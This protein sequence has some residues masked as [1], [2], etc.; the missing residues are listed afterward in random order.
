MKKV[1]VC[2]GLVGLL[3][4]GMCNNVKA[5]TSSEEKG[6]EESVCHNIGKTFV[7][8]GGKVIGCCEISI[9]MT[10][11]KDKSSNNK[12]IDFAFVR[13]SMK[14]ENSRKDIFGYSESLI[15]KSEKEI[16]GK[17][18]SYNPMLV[19]NENTYSI[20]SSNLSEELGVPEN[21]VF[22]KNALKIRNKSDTY[23]SEINMEYNYVHGLDRFRNK[24]YFYEESV[25]YLYWASETQNAS[26]SN[27]MIIIPEFEV[28]NSKPGYAATSCW[29]YSSKTVE[30]TYRIQ[31]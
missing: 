13:C 24:D 16:N 17:L 2:I 1:L 12:N 23:L 21:V 3:L 8:Y 4:F 28:W 18:R 11:A 6:F 25:Q 27:T 31:Y 30:V 9:G 26:Y 20:T 5:D 19:I 22:P 15:I 14:G 7:F 29:K 10:R